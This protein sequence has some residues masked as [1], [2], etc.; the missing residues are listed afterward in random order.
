VNDIQKLHATLDEWNA[1][2]DNGDIERLLATVDPDVIICNER[3]PTITGAQA[4]RNKYAPRL[5]AYH[6][7]S[8]VIVHETKIFGDFAVMV[9]TFEVQTKDKKSGEQGGGKGRLVL[10]YRRDQQGDWKMA[11]D[12]D[13]NA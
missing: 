9:L 13:N 7:E 4:L 2:L 8:K 11:L 6:F 12:V 5:A 10:G 1:A 3:Q